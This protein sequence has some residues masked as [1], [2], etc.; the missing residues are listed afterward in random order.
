M[1]GFVVKAKSNPNKGF[2]YKS[3][4]GSNPFSDV[5][6]KIWELVNRMTDRT[7]PSGDSYGFS[8]D[9]AGSA[10]RR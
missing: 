5:S 1:A 6:M 7:G 4:Y 3:A 9:P 10:R 8:D 2:D